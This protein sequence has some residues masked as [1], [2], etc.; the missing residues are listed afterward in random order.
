MTSLSERL[1]EDVKTAL[2]AGDK[3]RLQVLRMLVASLREAAD[4]A[5]GSLG[6]ADEIA[7][8]TRAVKSRKE[9]V[10][11][12]LAA[13]RQEFADAEAAE[14]EI[15]HGYLP[16]QL[17]G[18]ELLA[19]VREVA[20]EVGYGGP[21]DTGR[22]MQAWMSRFAGCADGRDVQAALRGLS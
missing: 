6:P 2:R 8:L 12:A 4:A 10:A 20:A 14:I 15:I 3:Q 7:V 17:S 18:D 22:F 11:Q 16:R 19:R 13:G 5:Q 21:K 9:S 1:T